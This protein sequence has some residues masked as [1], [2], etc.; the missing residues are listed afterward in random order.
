MQDINQHLERVLGLLGGRRFGLISDLDGTLSEIAPSPAEATLHPDC[1]RALEQ[2]KD[3]LAL[4]AL[5]SGRAASN[6][7]E[8]VG[9]GSLVYIGSHG[10]ER[11]NE[12]GLELAPGLEDYPKRISEAL[13]VLEAKLGT[14]GLTYENKGVTG[15]V[16]YRASPDPAAARRRILAAISETPQAAG[17]VVEENRRVADLLPPVAADKG[18]AVTALIRDYQLEAAVYLGDDR[19]D[20]TAFRA[21]RARRAAGGFEGLAVA[22]LSQ[23]MPAELTREAD[24]SVGGV[25]GVAKFLGLLAGA[26]SPG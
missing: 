6:A 23:E 18:S 16:H 5:V 19:T 3:R 4:V 2:L 25:S 24:F 13:A 8:M 14:T 10:L 20:L 9:L 11:L 7:R 21:L 15:A 17:L 1:R 22:V 12:S 26:V